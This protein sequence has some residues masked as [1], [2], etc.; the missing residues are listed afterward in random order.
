MFKIAIVGASGITGTELVKLIK[1]HESIEK[2]DLFSFTNAG[3]KIKEFS[4]DLIEY[5]DVLNNF[6]DIN[7]ENYDLVFFACPNGTVMKYYDALMKSGTKVIDLAAD[8]RLDSEK[9]WENFYKIKHLHP[10]DLCNVV[11]GLTE[12][13]REKIKASQ[14]I[15]NPGCYP[16][17]AILAIY[18]LLKNNVIDH[19]TII[20]DAK[21]GF[22]GAGKQKIDSGLGSQIKNNLIPYN[23]FQHR[24]QIEISQ[25]LSKASNNP[26]ELTFTPHVLSVYRGI[27]ETIYVDLTE[28]ISEKQIINIYKNFYENEFFINIEESKIVELKDVANTN[29]VSISCHA[30]KKNKLIIVSAIDNLLK[31]AAGQAI[32]NMNLMLGVDEKTSLK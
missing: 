14:I 31:G 27:I 16:T 9:D 30:N 22:S 6:N 13:N 20:V 26:I 28:K 1:K 29:N 32:Q 5:D 4:N 18:P 15:A 24:H 8:F 3:K 7:F 10:E 19:K 25:E 17:A 2:V 12:L 23:I 21:S 11:Y